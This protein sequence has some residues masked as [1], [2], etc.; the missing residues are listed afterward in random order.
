M[1]NISQMW[2]VTED[3]WWDEFFGSACSARQIEFYNLALTNS[4]CSKIPCELLQVISEY[5]ADAYDFGERLDVENQDNVWS[6]AEVIGVKKASI[7]VRY[8]G[9]HSS[10]SEWIPRDSFRLANLFTHTATFQDR[11]VSLICASQLSPAQS[12]G[13]TPEE[14]SLRFLGFSDQCIA[15]AIQKKGFHNAINFAFY[16]DHMERQLK[17]KKKNSF[18]IGDKVDIQDTYG[19]WCIAEVLRVDGIM[20]RV[21]YFGWLECYD[22]WISCESPRIAPAFTHTFKKQPLPTHVPEP[23][24]VPLCRIVRCGFS[25]DE[26]RAAA[27]AS[28]F[29]QNA[30]NYAFA[31]RHLRELE[32]ENDEE[33]AQFS[34]FLN[35]DKFY[36][37]Q[38]VDA[39]DPYDSWAVGQI[40]ALLPGKAKVR[41]LGWSGALNIWVPLVE[42]RIAPLF[43]HTKKRQARSV[44]VESEEVLHEILRNAGIDDDD[45]I[46]EAISCSR[47]DAQHALNLGFYLLDQQD[48]QL[49]HEAEKFCH[50]RMN[51]DDPWTMADWNVETH[52][53]QDCSDS[54]SSSLVWFVDHPGIFCCATHIRLSEGSP[55]CDPKAIRDDSENRSIGDILVRSNGMTSMD[56]RVCVPQTWRTWNAI[57]D[58]G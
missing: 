6:V 42:A 20:I 36:V 16:S 4:L 18:V 51:L 50:Q 10:F 9:K 32:E 38:R 2:G 56:S 14:R 30:I 53:S 24:T 21:S 7:R 52:A 37:G 22:E 26:A 23:R 34:S 27:E 29:A 25:I 33:S 47:M 48:S 58:N 49:L 19:T 57:F 28:D 40:A 54:G 1:I 35:M 55:A 46:K 13:T 17:G 45:V 8:L 43:T 41:F 11:A 15:D 39:K 3:D 31:Q 5:A 44:S 12:L